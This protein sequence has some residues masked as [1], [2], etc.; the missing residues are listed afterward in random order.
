ML[1]PGEGIVVSVP[2]TGSR[3]LRERLGLRK[4]IHTTKEWTYLWSVVED[5]KLY[6][7]LRDPR[8]TWLSHMRR[9]PH[10]RP[11]NICEWVGAWFKLHALSL[12]K[13]I[14]FI[15]IEKQDHPL[16][17]DWSPVGHWDG[18]SDSG[19][20]PEPDLKAIYDIPIIKKHY[21]L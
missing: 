18:D 3:F 11:F 16:I 20:M 12:V 19:W 15:P 10:S 21:G 6:A 9:S 13:E 17:T 8:Q 14:E 7:P 2:H 1:D 5:K 4:I